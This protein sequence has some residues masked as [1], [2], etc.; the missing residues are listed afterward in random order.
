M[1]VSPYARPDFVLHDVLDHTSVLKLIE[2]KWNLPPLDPQGRRRGL[3]ARRARPRRAARVP[4]PA[5][6]ARAEGGRLPP[7]GRPE[8]GSPPAVTAAGDTRQ[9]SSAQQEVG[10]ALA[11]H[12][13][14]GVG[15]A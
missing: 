2:E 1:I 5:G 12:D 8:A 11:D 6:P 7:V 9:A 13:A 14:R 4:D 3:P 15:V 10:A